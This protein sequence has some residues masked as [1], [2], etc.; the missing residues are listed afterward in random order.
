MSVG[1]L[2]LESILRQLA[3]SLFLCAG[4]GP[5]DMHTLV[6]YARHYISKSCLIAIK[7]AMYISKLHTSITSTLK[8]NIMRA[9]FYQASKHA[10]GRINIYVNSLS[11]VKKMFT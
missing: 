4:F 11:S 7:C 6:Q 10:H 5:D 8:V 3:P 1:T 2:D 9:T